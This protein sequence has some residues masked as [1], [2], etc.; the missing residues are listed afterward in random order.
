[1]DDR[2]LEEQLFGRWAAT[3]GAPRPAPTRPLP[4]WNEVHLE[5]R[6]P[7]VTLQLL[8][9]G[10][11]ERHPGGFGYSRFAENYRIWARR[12]DVVLHRGHR[13]GEKLFIDFAGQTVPI[14]NAATGEMTQA[15]VFV[16]VLG[17]S[18]HT[19]VELTRSQEL[20]NW[21]D[22]HVHTFEHIGRVPQIVVPDNAKVGLTHAHR[23]EPEL[24]RTYQDLAAHHRFAVIPARPRKPRDKAKVEVGVQVAERWILARLR[25]VKFFS[26]EEAN[27]AVRTL[28]D[29]L[30]GKDFK[31]MPGSSRPSLFETL[32]RPALQ[33]LPERRYEFATWRMAKV[34][35]DYHVEV[36]RH[37]Y[38]A[39]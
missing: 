14:T 28:L 22:A 5:L 7:H 29:Q 1:M 11:K 16:A 27:A 15:E 23:H 18:S 26:L 21:I 10:Y 6:R 2:A 20:P 39:P 3:S 4:D 31:K 12:L 17:A 25:N 35:I 32:D 34:D 13:A 19:Y 9:T 24:N 37:L 36:D 30:S 8:W 38:S 33:P